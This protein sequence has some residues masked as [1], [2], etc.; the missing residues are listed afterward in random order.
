[1]ELIVGDPY[2]SMWDLVLCQF[3]HKEKHVSIEWFSNRLNDKSED[4][5]EHSWILVDWVVE[6]LLFNWVMFQGFFRVY[7][8]GIE[9]TNDLKCLGE[10]IHKFGWFSNEKWK[11]KFIRR[12]CGGPAHRAPITPKRLGGGP[13]MSLITLGSCREPLMCP[14]QH[15]WAVFVVYLVESF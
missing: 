9:V 2:Q 7:K 10:E 12:T 15:F 13:K 14:N 3:T 8:L 6:Y 4:L 1:M 5:E 11:D